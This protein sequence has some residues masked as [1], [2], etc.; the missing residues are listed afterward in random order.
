MSAAIRVEFADRAS[1][2]AM[3][4]VAAT[5]VA[6]L[7][8]HKS[9]GP[10][11]PAQVLDSLNHAPAMTDWPALNVAL[12]L[13][14][15]G[16]IVAAPLLVAGSATI[17]M[18]VLSMPAAE[19]SQALRGPGALACIQVGFVVVLIAALGL[20]QYLI[21]SDPDR[22]NE[23]VLNSSIYVAGLSGPGIAGCWLTMSRSASA[24]PP[25][26]S[27]TVDKAERA[28]AACSPTRLGTGTS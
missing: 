8:I 13:G 22:V 10:L 26:C 9:V 7:L 27:P 20:V 25:R 28:A 2:I 4:L 15:L 19:R 11:D 18:V 14:A 3:V 16:V 24:V 12:F 6:C 1:R 5:A 17:V 21:D 23:I